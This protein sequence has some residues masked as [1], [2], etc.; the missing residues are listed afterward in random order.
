MD[1]KQKYSENIN[2]WFAKFHSMYLRIG[3]NSFT[4]GDF[5]SSGPTCVSFFL[6]AELSSG[7][8]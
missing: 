5:V 6:D 8:D 2:I 7:Q 3:Y 4:T 1:C